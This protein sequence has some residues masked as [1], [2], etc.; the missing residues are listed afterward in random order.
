MLDIIGHVLNIHVQDAVGA[1]LASL[2]SCLGIQVGIKRIS[3]HLARL[4]LCQV[5]VILLSSSS[6]TDMETEEQ[7]GKLL[8]PVTHSKCWNQHQDLGSLSPESTLD[9][10]AHYC[11]LGGTTRRSQI[12]LKFY[13]A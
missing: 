3:S 12:A 10:T 9:I 8:F 7:R 6:Y 4:I 13:A 1:P 11:L 2:W 5:I